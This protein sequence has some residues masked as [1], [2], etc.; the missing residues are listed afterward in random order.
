MSK[1]KSVYVG[2]HIALVSR[3]D[4][5][6]VTRPNI[7]GIVGIVAVTDAGNLLLVEQYRPPLDKRVI[8]LP[9]GLAGD[10]AHTRG[11]DLIAAAKR[12]LLEET[13]YAAESMELLTE[14]AASAGI[15]DEIIT[16]YRARGLRKTGDGGGDASEQIVVHEIP[17]TQLRGWLDERRRAGVVIDLKVFAGICFL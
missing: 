10:S 16:L 15:T 14:G 4:W 11:E 12:E 9:A 13:G 1:P 8:E 2:K 7:G 17:L 6:Y 5:E 3:D